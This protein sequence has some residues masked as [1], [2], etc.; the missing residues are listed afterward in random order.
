MPYI[1]SLNCGSSSL[2]A[3]LFLVSSPSSPLKVI[4]TA[5]ASNVGA[6]GKKVVLEV[7]WEGVEAE[8]GGEVK[9]E[10]EQED[11]QYTDLPGLVLGILT[12]GEKKKVDKEEIRWVT[13]R[14]V[15]GS[16]HTKPIVV[17]KKHTGGLKEMDAL[18]AFAPLHNHNAV[19]AVGSCLDALP[20][21]TS[22]LLFDT[23]FH[24]TLSKEI[25]TYAVPKLEESQ[26]TPVPLRKYGF[27]G[28]SYASVLRSLASHLEM[29]QKELDV[30]VCHLGSGGSVCQIEK[31]RSVDTSMGLTPLEGIIGGTR[32]GTIDPTLIFHHTPD[33][34]T[35]VG[36]AGME[37]SKA[38]LVLNKSSGLLAL[39]GTSD[40]GLILERM[41]D[42]SSCS[43]EEHESATL[44]YQVYLDRLLHFVSFYLFKLL[45]SGSTSPIHIVFSGG[46]GERAARLRSDVVSKLAWLGVEVDEDANEK[47]GKGDEVVE[48]IS[49]EKESGGGRLSVWVVK[50]DEEEQCAR[51]ARE[52]V[53]C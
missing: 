52:E 38:E 48:R 22:I 9:I 16:T 49:K 8:Q 45:A 2:K 43:K 25:Y 37:V 6:K 28:L 23:M 17:T 31:G 53:G 42:S 27:H 40:F 36:E 10:K 33:C 7:V 39:A 30:V 24:Q 19:L 44:A 46:I 41:N 14:I 3:K 13:H 1:L 18:S 35:N 29:E 12:E 15:H 51:M 34:S 11:V 26:K 21:H 4:A 5:S 32:C 47:N 20:S 50:T